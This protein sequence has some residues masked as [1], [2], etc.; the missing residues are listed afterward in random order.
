MTR[1]YLDY[2]AQAP[3]R[4]EASR[5]IAAA[6]DDELGNPSSAHRWGHR[7]K[8]LLEQAR[9]QVAALLSARPEEIVFTS[10]ATE[11]NNLALYGAADAAAAPGHLIVSRIEHSSVL[12]P[13]ADLERRG[14]TVSRIPPDGD[15]WVDPQRVLEA[16]RADTRLVSLMHSNHEVGTLQAVSDLGPELRRRGVLLHSDA[17]QSAGKVALSARAL[18]ADLISLSSGKLGGACGSGCLWVRQDAPLSPLQRGGSQEGRRRAGTQALALIAGFGAAAEA[19]ANEIEEEARR[20][21]A[22]RDRLERMLMQRF[23]SARLHGVRRPRLPGT[24][25]FSLPEARGE[26]LV[27]ALDLEGVAVSAGSAC[28]AGTMQASHVLEAMGIPSSE[29][30]SAVRVSL[31]HGSSAGEVDLLL[32]ALSRI[33]DRVARKPG[34]CDVA[35]VTALP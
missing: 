21:Q 13:A 11:A 9:R 25:N 34:A 17:A 24:S 15:G 28:D 2:N 3:I 35:G 31:G 19:A 10:G 29:T 12:E 5:T 14:W 20:L 8:V 32:E 30:A 22:L 1:A 26:D 33:L 16:L 4:P 7:A 23:P 18:G 6:L 27:L